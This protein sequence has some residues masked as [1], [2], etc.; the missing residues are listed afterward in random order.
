M[1]NPE[2]WNKILSPEE[3]IRYQFSL[4]KHYLDRI[5][6]FWVVLGIFLIPLFGLGI[7]FIINGFFL[8]WYMKKTNNYAFTNKRVLILRGWLS[9]TLVSIDYD[10]ITDVTVEENFYQKLIFR[11][12]RLLIDTA[13]SDFH[14]EEFVLNNIEDPYQIKRKLDEIR[15][16]PVPSVVAS[17]LPLL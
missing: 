16:N 1:D 9:T 11:T 10:K 2:I 6:D 12:G 8:Y 15:E 7:I 13:G 4:G 14:E 3:K 17:E 5:R